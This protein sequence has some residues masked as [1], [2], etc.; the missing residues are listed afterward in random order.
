MI[1]LG[2][3]GEIATRTLPDGRVL[4]VSPLGWG[5]ALLGIIRVEDLGLGIYSDVW[6]YQSRDAAL[7]ALAAWDGEGEPEGWYRHPATGRRRPGGDPAQ[8]FVRE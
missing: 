3:R 7:V 8:E 6:Q 1:V 5:Y 2:I 4:D